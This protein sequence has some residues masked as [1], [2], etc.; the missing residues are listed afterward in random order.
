MPRIKRRG[1]V[2]TM[3]TFEQAMEL[4]LGPINVSAPPFAND[5]ERRSAWKQYRD[6]LLTSVNE[7]SRPWAFWVYEVGRMPNRSA[8]ERD[9]DLLRKL[10]LLTDQERAILAS[11]SAMASMLRRPQ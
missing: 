3:L 7:F 10:N 6:E 1:H 9:V 5:R 11:N 4:I 2:V 8:G